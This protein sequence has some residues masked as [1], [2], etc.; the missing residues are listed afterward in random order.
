MDTTTRIFFWVLC[1]VLVVTEISPAAENPGDSIITGA[2]F[3]KDT[4]PAADLMELITTSSAQTKG[5]LAELPKVFAPSLPKKAPIATPELQSVAP[6]DHKSV[7]QTFGRLPMVFEPNRGQASQD[8]KFLSR[9]ADYSLFLTENEAVIV[10]AEQKTT[11]AASTLKNVVQK[12]KLASVHGSEAGREP[13][14]LALRMRLVGS[15]TAD[16]FGIEESP[17]RS[18]Y[19]NG[20]NPA[21]WHTDI[22]HYAKVKYENVYP[23]IDLVYYGNGRQ[24]E[25]DFIVAPNGDPR[26]IRIAFE[27]ADNVEVDD[28][29]N[30]LVETALGNLRFQKPSVY[31]DLDGERKEIAGGYSLV[32]EA[33]FGGDFV[34]GAA[35]SRADIVSFQVASYDVHKPLVIDPVLLYS[36]YLGGGSDVSH[37][38]SDNA[39][40][41]AADSLGNAYVT[42]RTTS[43]WF[44]TTAGAFQSACEVDE[45]DQCGEH[46]FVSKINPS[47]SALIYSTY[48]GRGIGRGIA[49]DRSG[50]AYI[51]GGTDSSDFPVTVGAFQ[52]LH[53]GGADA[54]VGKLNASGNAL[55]YSTYVG[56]LFFDHATAIA[57]DSSGSAY[58]TGLTRSMDFPTTPGAFYAPSHPGDFAFVTKLSS[59]G[60]RLSYSTY[61]GS[62]TSGGNAIAVDPHGNAFVTGYTQDFDF[63]TTDNAFQRFCIPDPFIPH[64]CADAFLAKFNVEGS[65]LLYSTYFGGSSIEGGYTIALD[66][67][68]YAYIAGGTYSYDLPV[69]QGV[70]QPYP[71]GLMDAF[72]AKFDTTVGGPNSL[73]YATYLGGA[74]YDYFAGIGLDSSGNLYLVGGTESYD[75]PLKDPLNIVHPPS[76]RQPDDPNI[77]VVGLDPTASQIIFSTYWGGSKWDFPYGGLALDES[78]NIYIAGWTVSLDFPASSDV[79]QPNCAD[80]HSTSCDDA[81]VAKISPVAANS[82][83]ILVVPPFQ[84]FGTQVSTVGDTRSF[85]V[86]NLGTA[87]LTGIATTSAPFVISGG[88]SYIIGAGDKQVVYVSRTGATALGTYTRSVNFTGG[89]GATATVKVNIIAGG[90]P[91]LNI[92]KSGPGG[93]SITGN[94]VDCN[95][96]CAVALPPGSNIALTAT[97]AAGSLFY[98]WAG[99]CTGIGPCALTMNGSK[100]VYAT[101]T[102]PLSIGSTFLPAAEANMPYNFVLTP[103]GGSP[104]YTLTVTKGSL[105]PG[106]SLGS[107]VIAG[108]PTR[109]GTYNF[110]IQVSDQ[111]GG[112]VSQKL[113]IKVLKAVTVSTKSL[114]T[115]RINRTYSARLAA[116]GGQAPY[117]WSLVSGTLPEGLL[118][119]PSNGSITGT[120]TAAAK[121]NLAFQVTDSLGGTVQKTLALTVR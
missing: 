29:G 93:G 113:Q 63:P 53:A 42:G 104:P 74:S 119:N 114:K 35:A 11:V 86:W 43:N 79:F 100:T 89:G 15:A 81:F 108:T 27:G 37:G 107:P 41:I 48:L 32:K 57:V 31:Q 6:A 95:D 36:T 80:F 14:K 98:G 38:W 67:A 101:F 78:A 21:N 111:L 106:L 54:F 85:S 2:G 51:T 75:F 20:N 60:T 46:V 117:S 91:I 47:G 87:T 66:Q 61:L 105:P 116:T 112:S 59:D 7:L 92:V 73:R 9:G 40:A 115:G 18:N 77:F 56:G 65:A 25:Y 68:G 76:G 19:F 102:T 13:K 10:L 3:D 118:F 103:A 109:A 5:Q 28:G 62:G 17:G 58:I 4:K 72:V 30:L 1:L 24:L 34:V 45:Y 94:G 120:P 55:L 70:I 52:T 39:F 33:N 26:N 22:P 97:P 71:A 121:A 82:A 88:G 83:R 64:F 44:P 50:N 12:K 69:T 84:D 49:V 23:G 110:T 99:D 96:S 90:N 8:V 16:P